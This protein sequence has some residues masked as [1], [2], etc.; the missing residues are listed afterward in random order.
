MWLPGCCLL[1]LCW[2][3]PARCWAALVAVRKVRPVSEWLTNEDADLSY[4]DVS[5]GGVPHDE[6]Q[7]ATA[8]CPRQTIPDSC[9][10]PDGCTCLCRDCDCGRCLG[11]GEYDCGG[12]CAH[13]SY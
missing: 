12:R 6:R 11:C 5:G 1:D 8:C 13:D 3:L 4:P 2:L 7:S 10:C 9:S